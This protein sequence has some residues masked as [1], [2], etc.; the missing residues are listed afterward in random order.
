MIIEGKC[1]IELGHSD[2]I[3][4]WEIKSSESQWPN[5]N[6]ISM[7]HRG[8]QVIKAADFYIMYIW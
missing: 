2:S 1:P 5:L 8:G 3:K 7:V 4:A 6:N